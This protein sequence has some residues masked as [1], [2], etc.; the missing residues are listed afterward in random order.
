MSIE[1]ITGM[2]GTNHV[3]SEDV[4][5]LNAELIGNGNYLL[6]GCEVTMT[7]ANTCHVAA[8]ELLLQG[9]HVRIKGA[10]EDVS[11]GNG[12]AGYN[13]RYLICLVYSK[14]TSGIETVELQAF[15]GAKTTGTATDPAVS[16]GSILGGDTNVVVP[17]ARLELTGLSVGTP[18]VML[19]SVKG[20]VAL[21]AETKKLGDSVSQTKTFYLNSP[22]M[23]P[24][25]NAEAPV[26]LNVC[27]NV[28]TLYINA[29]TTRF[30]SDYTE[31]VDSDG[32]KKIGEYLPL[33]FD[34][35]QQRNIKGENKPVACRLCGGSD[36]HLWLIKDSQ[37]GDGSEMR[38][39]FTWVR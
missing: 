29:V 37:L 34:S 25:I 15:A 38:F 1:L 16:A 36:P 10:G 17:L 31:L 2:G 23:V 35:E 9:R 13:Q 20:L 22:C 32:L 11:I 21:G 24:R 28:C 12:Q 18:A 30:I 14:A 26:Q 5:A 6:S 33:E 4:G 8:G 19:D 27:G 39:V 7:D 3:D